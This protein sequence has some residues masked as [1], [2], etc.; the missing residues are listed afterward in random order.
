MINMTGGTLPAMTWQ[1]VMAFGHQNLE[2]RPIPGLTAEPSREGRRVAACQRAERRGANLPDRN[3]VAALLRG[4]GLDRQLVQNRGIGG[5]QAPIAR[6][7]KLHR[8]NGHDRPAESCDALMSRRDRALLSFRPLKQGKGLND[9][10]N[11]A[12]PEG[13]GRRESP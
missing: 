2:I 9:E 3:P 13:A 7:T 1:E 12:V 8:A 11:P 4:V 5:C 6:P 10:R